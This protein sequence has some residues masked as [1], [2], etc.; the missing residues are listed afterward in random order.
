MAAM[1]EGLVGFKHLFNAMRPL[2]SRARSPP[3]CNRPM[4]AMA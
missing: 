1:A 2:A 3:R 4:P